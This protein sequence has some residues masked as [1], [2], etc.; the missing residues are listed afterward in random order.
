MCVRFTNSD[1]GNLLVQE[2][3][4]S[5]KRRGAE[6]TTIVGVRLGWVIIG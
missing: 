4:K 3:S 6:N 1:F 5:R 2:P